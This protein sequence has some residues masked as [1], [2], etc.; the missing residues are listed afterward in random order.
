M[1]N[2]TQARKAALTAIK[3]ELPLAEVRRMLDVYNV[4]ADETHSSIYQPKKSSDW[5]IID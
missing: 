1:S 3:N 4:Y 5:I 2:L